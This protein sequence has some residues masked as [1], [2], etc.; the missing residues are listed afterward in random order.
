M[1]DVEDP[2]ED[3]RVSP[4]K[5]NYQAPDTELV[6]TWIWLSQQLGEDLCRF[7]DVLERKTNP[8]R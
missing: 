3:G 7:R 6:Q 2:G 5:K 8:V 1:I 4:N